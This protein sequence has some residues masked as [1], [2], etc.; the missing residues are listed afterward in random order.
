[1]PAGDGPNRRA[2]VRSHQ[3]NDAIPD[4]SAP[5]ATEIFDSHLQ[6][7]GHRHNAVPD[8]AVARHVK[9]LPETFPGKAEPHLTGGH[10]LAAAFLADKNRFEPPLAKFTEAGDHKIPGIE[11]LG[12]KPITRPAAS[13]SA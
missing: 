1:S 10:Q 6:L 3:Q 8:R 12:F 9:R 13:I 2:S 4:E 7:R 11:H 5:V